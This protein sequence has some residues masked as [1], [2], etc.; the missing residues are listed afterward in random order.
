MI[1]MSLLMK[2]DYINETRNIF[3][4]GYRERDLPCTSVE[5]VN[6]YCFCDKEFND[7]YS[8]VLIN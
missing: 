2:M 4:L 8:E 1:H 6:W 7:F 3:W 5:M